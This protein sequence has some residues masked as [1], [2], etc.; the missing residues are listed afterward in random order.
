MPAIIFFL[1]MGAA[2]FVALRLP[3]HGSKLTDVATLLAIILLSA[4][5]VLLAIDQTRRRTAGK[6]FIPSIVPARIIIL[7]A[8]DE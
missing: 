6:Q 4:A 1:T 2:I 5:L 8:G 3:R 7:I